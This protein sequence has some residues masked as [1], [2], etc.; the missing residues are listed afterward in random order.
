MTARTEKEAARLEAEWKVACKR[1]SV[2]LEALAV[3]L[4]AHERNKNVELAAWKELNTAYAEQERIWNFAYKELVGRRDAKARRLEAL[5]R[6]EKEAE[7]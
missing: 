4:E 6:K 2:A 7:G 5:A 3:L 1:V